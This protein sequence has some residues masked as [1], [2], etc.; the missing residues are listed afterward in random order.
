[1][2]GRKTITTQGQKNTFS[3]ISIQGHIF[4]MGK[5]HNVKLTI[6]TFNSLQLSDI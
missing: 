4:V 2:S 1:M 5:A 6:L 3:S